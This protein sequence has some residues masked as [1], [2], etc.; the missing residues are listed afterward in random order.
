MRPDPDLLAAVLRE[1]R[2][3]SLPAPGRVIAKRLG[4]TRLRSIGECARAARL[5]GLGVTYIPGQG[6]VMAKSRAER[7]ACAARMERA[8]R[9][10]LRAARALRLGRSRQSQ[11]PAT[12]QRRATA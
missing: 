7:L 10:E 3:R 12:R 9:A 6:Y 1:L 11:I 8:A 4:V 5:K 2:R